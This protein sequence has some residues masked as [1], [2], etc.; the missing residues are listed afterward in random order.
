MFLIRKKKKV[1]DKND[2]LLRVLDDNGN[3][4]GFLEKRGVVHEEKK[5]YGNVAIWIIDRTTGDIL[6]EKRSREKAHNPSKWALIGGHI[7]NHDT[8]EDTVFSEVK[9][10]IGVKLN[11]KRIKKLC[12]LKPV[13]SNK[14]GFSHHFY[15]IIPSKIIKFRLQKEE[16]EKVK[17][18]NYNKFKNKI[19]SANEKYSG[20][21]IRYKDAFTKLDKILFDAGILREKYE[22]EEDD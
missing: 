8:P 12:I 15:I 19:K 6:I 1:A 5:Y 13:K 3:W 4:L 22:Y 18:I 2:E 17:Y 21:W 16:V 14:Y 20:N 10:E 9:E 11:K 7:V